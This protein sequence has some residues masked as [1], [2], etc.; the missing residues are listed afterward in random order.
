MQVD[1]E[2]IKQTLFKLHNLASYTL[3]DGYRVFIIEQFMF[4]PF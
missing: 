3:A 4:A 1:I 2:W